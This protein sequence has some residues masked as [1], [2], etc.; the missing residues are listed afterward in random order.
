MEQ[1]N[2]SIPSAGTKDDSSTKA[3]V[4]TSSPNNAKPYVGG[5][6]CL[7]KWFLFNDFERGNF[8]YFFQEYLLKN[9]NKFNVHTAYNFALL[10]RELQF[11]M[12]I[13]QGRMLKHKDITD[14]EVV[15]NNFW[16]N[17]IMSYTDLID[18][19]TNEFESYYNKMNI[20]QQYEYSKMSTVSYFSNILNKESLLIETKNLLSFLRFQ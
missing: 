16:V 2:N 8:Q 10:G 4:K 3:D 6:F 18:F 15:T 9:E 5:S 1:N 20:E 7:A 14:R 12:R 11:Q 13:L 19:I 17:Q